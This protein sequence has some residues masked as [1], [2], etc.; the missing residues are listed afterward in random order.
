MHSEIKIKIKSKDVGKLL[1]HQH[2]WFSFSSLKGH[3]IP[4]K[5]QAIS[6]SAYRRASYCEVKMGDGIQGNFNCCGF[7][8]EFAGKW[9]YTMNYFA[10]SIC[11]LANTEEYIE[12]QLAGNLGEVLIRCNNVMYIREAPQ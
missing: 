6:N 9:I 4:R 11:Q 10:Y 8:Y 7:V 2:F 1:L 3:R 5:S 12:G